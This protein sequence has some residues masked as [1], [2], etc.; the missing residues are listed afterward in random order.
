MTEL[1]KIERAKMY[2]D[3]L[4][5]GVNP[6]DDSIVPEQDAINNVR[7]SR[8]FFFV[9]D[10]LRQVIENGGI[11]PQKKAVHKEKK[12]PFSLPVEQRNSFQFSEDPIA[13][14]VLA[15]RI[16]DLI[17]TNEMAPLKYSS[18][19]SWLVAIG[20]LSLPNPDSLRKTKIPTP[21]GNRIG[22]TS[23]ERV[24]QNGPYTGVFYDE[25]AQHFIMD[26]LDAI[27]EFEKNSTELQGHSW[28]PQ[29]DQCLLD[30]YRKGVPMEEIAVTLKRNN[31]SIRSRLKKLGVAE[32][33]VI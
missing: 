32:Q 2:I 23:E 15:R 13:I 5:N 33:K 10:V 8:C 21:E 12:L 25:T 22:I 19:T 6:I 16:N 24:G 1:E 17:N 28:T 4:A 9:S 26:N 3:K 20:M 31:S 14:S 27:L 29:Q 30:L 7:L 18:I 11:G